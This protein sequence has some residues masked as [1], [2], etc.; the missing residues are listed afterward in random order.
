[1][2]LECYRCGEWNGKSCKCKDRQTLFLGDCR[3][4]ID[5]IGDVS[6]DLVLT[7]P[8]YSSGGAMR[9]DRSLEPSKKYRD[10]DSII[11][12]PEFSG[13]N[14]DQRSFTLWCS[15]WMAAA[16]WKTRAGG[17]LLCFIDWRN[18]PCVIDAT[19]VGGWVYRSLIPWDKTG[20]QRPRRGWFKAQCEYIVGCSAGTLST[21]GSCSGGFFEIVEEEQAD[22]ESDGR[23]ARCRVVGAAKQHI[24]EKPVKL[25]EMLINTREDWQV[26]FDPFA[27]SGTTLKACKSLGRQGIG[28]EAS[29]EYCDVISRR[30]SQGVLF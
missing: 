13:D 18:L 27:G 8:P 15:D 25:C 17:A 14:R 30:L 4:V 22:G 19:Q 7:D 11:S 2:T 16:L 20:S 24:T 12:D 10:H 26:V 21:E 29:R 23:L 6:F 1:M 5:Q 3:E 28:I 9:S